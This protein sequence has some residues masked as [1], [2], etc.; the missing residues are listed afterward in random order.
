MAYVYLVIKNYDN[1]EPFE[2]GYSYAEIMGTFETKEAAL[3]YISNFNVPD[4]VYAN[5]DA[6]REALKEE[7]EDLNNSDVKYY[8]DFEDFFEDRSRYVMKISMV[9]EMKPYEVFTYSDL[10]NPSE[11]IKEIK[12]HSNNYE[13]PL[14]MLSIVEQEVMK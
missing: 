8:N 7:W 5:E 10:H 13:N 4:G 12:Y 14:I 11:P 9:S 6:A 3:N 2:D 1:C